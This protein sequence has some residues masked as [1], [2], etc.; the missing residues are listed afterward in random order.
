[1]LVVKLLSHIQLFCDLMDCSLPDSSDCGILQDRI[2][3][4]VA[5]SVCRSSQWIEPELPALVGRFFFFFFLTT[6]LPGKPLMIINIALFQIV[7]QPKLSPVTTPPR[8]NCNKSSTS[9]RLSIFPLMTLGLALHIL[10]SGLQFLP[11]YEVKMV[12]SRQMTSRY[13]TMGDFI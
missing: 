12:T 10:S 13:L 5:I 3:Q 6:G 1:M 2:L 7:F 9:K 4:W 11:R 8:F